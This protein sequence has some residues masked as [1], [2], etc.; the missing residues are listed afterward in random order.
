MAL[1]AATGFGWHV[2]PPVPFQLLWDGA[3]MRW[4]LSPAQEWAQFESVDVPGFRE[5]WRTECPIAD[6]Y[7]APFAFLHVGQEPGL[8]R[9]WTGLVARTRPGWSL[10]VRAPANIPGDPAF[11]VMEGIVEQDWWFGPVLRVSCRPGG[12]RASSP[13]PSP[14]PCTSCAGTRSLRWW[15]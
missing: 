5:T 14:V 1:T 9:L 11:H 3:T 15:R 13:P 10:L 4:R 2:Y 8:V 12:R 6:Y 7:P